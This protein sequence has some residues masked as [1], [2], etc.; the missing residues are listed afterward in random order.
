MPAYSFDHFNDQYFEHLA[1]ALAQENLAKGLTPYGAGRDGGREATYRGRMDYPTGA[2]PWEGYLVVQAKF[3][4]SRAEDKRKEATWAIGQLNKEME[5]YE[6]GDRETPDY[7]LF[8]TNAVLTPVPEKGG[9]DRFKARLE[10]WRVAL[11]MTAADVWHSDKIAALLDASSHVASR[12]GM[13]HGG[14]VLHAVASRL[15]GEQKQADRTL[16]LYLQ[17]ELV[18]ERSVRL[19]QAGH[20]ADESPALARVFVDLK[21]TGYDTAA[22]V[23]VVSHVQSTSDRP[24]RARADSGEREPSELAPFAPPT[25][26]LGRYAVIGGPGSG[27]TTLTQ[28]L[29]QRHRAALLL[30]CG[31][32]VEEDARGALDATQEEAEGSGDGL[33]AHARIPFR[34]VLDRFAD[35]LANDRAASVAE[36]VADQVHRRTGRAFTSDDVE[37]LLETAPLLFAFDGLDEVPA[38]SN[39][40]AVLEAV[41]DFLRL[42]RDAEADLLVLTTTRPQG[43]NEEFGPGGFTHLLLQPLS[44]ERAMIYAERFADSRYHADPD[45]KEKVVGRLREA[46]KEPATARLMTSPLQV[47]IMAALV[48]LVG[49]PPRER[50]ALFDRYYDIVYQREQERGLSASQV[51]ADHRADIDAIHDAIGLRL[52]VETEGS[53]RARAHTRTR[54]SYLTTEQLRAVVRARLK[55]EGYEGEALVGLVRQLIGVALNRLVFIVPQEEGR[56][57]FEVR[58]LQEF[59]AARAIMRGG[60][61]HVKRRL[62]AIAPAPYW[63]NVTLFAIGKAFTGRE[64]REDLQDLASTLCEELDLEGPI[65]GLLPGARLALD[66]IEDGILDRKPRSYDKFYARALD[67][68]SLSDRSVGARLADAFLPEKHDDKARQALARA[69]PLAACAFLARLESQDVAWASSAL[70]EAW[71]IDDEA[72]R[73][74]YDALASILT[75]T[76]E[77]TAHA[78]ALAARSPV[79]WAARIL[80]RHLPDSWIAESKKLD[81]ALETGDWVPLVEDE[82]TFD[83]GDL[84]KR[85]VSFPIV[86]AR[87]APEAVRRVAEVDTEHPSWAY[88][89]AVLPW[90]ENPTPEGL[91]DAFEAYAGLQGESNEQYLPAAFGWQLTSAADGADTEELRSLATRARSGGLGTPEAW[92]AAEKRWGDWAVSPADWAE[93]TDDTW[94]YSP[95]IA[96]K[97]SA[98]FIGVSAGSPSEDWEPAVFRL[99]DA[100]A[101]TPSRRAKSRLAFALWFHLSAPSRY[102]GVTSLSLSDLESLIELNSKWAVSG[103]VASLLPTEDIRI[104]QAERIDSL[105]CSTRIDNRGRQIEVVEPDSKR[106][107]ALAQLAGPGRDGVIRLLLGLARSERIQPAPLSVAYEELGSIGKTAHV[108]LDALSGHTDP[109]SLVERAASLRDVQCPATSRPEMEP[110]LTRLFKESPKPVGLKRAAALFARDGRFGLSLRAAASGALEEEAKEIDSGLDH[111][112]NR[113]V[114]GMAMPN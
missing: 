5:A 41:A 109:N 32:S 18:S 44:A 66:V 42:A 87:I 60:Y 6:R 59:A 9:L 78:E 68:L 71:P 48:D 22:E 75:W 77:R 112:D 31:K 85:A 38:T 80:A 54:S 114:Y 113:A 28:L 40:E 107:E 49:N 100:I 101:R 37:R 106:Y 97:G 29:A 21:A 55:E 57:S 91:A 30:R 43:Y 96:S 76:P 83:Q 34:V 73:A 111:M 23:F 47:T 56:Y 70:A 81:P 74:V 16:R 58:S 63:R 10:E 95:A 13:L 104:E 4:E 26:D 46:M 92:A 86:R 52:Q 24:L 39:R 84:P 94:P 8:I 51:L 3:K 20:D 82:R 102:Q 105:G 93:I 99:Q 64:P 17:K 36:F 110:L 7:Y 14:D 72:S 12:F 79:W 45:R 27:K 50:Y 67:L 65:L 53:R 2:D 62:R 90:L 15:L 103:A 1:V 11:G 19:A 98:P 25:S 89:T 108:G 35:A 69:S 33:P 88:T 61:E